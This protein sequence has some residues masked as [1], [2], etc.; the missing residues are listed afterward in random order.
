MIACARVQ[1]IRMNNRLK[2]TT[3]FLASTFLCA[4]G[5]AN[6]EGVTWGFRYQTFWH[7]VDYFDLGLPLNRV[8]QWIAYEIFAIL[9]FAVGA[10]LLGFAVRSINTSEQK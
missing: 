1:V 8:P 2:I 10:F 9:P 6:L 5:Y 3:L 7:T 4:V